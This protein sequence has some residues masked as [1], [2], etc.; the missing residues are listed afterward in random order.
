MLVLNLS[1]G[2][3]QIYSEGDL[4]T[5]AAT[6]QQLQQQRL[7]QHS[8]TRNSCFNFTKFLKHLKMDGHPYTMLTLLL[9]IMAIGL[10]TDTVLGNPTQQQHQHQQQQYQQTNT[11]RVQQC[12]EGC[13]EK[14]YS[15]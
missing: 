6:Q 14:I 13:L 15:Q 5:A 7:S 1:E 3:L 10:C 4:T 2:Y 11:V 9:V 12:R 8:K